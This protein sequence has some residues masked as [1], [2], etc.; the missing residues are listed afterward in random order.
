[1]D[2][3]KEGELEHVVSRAR[4]LG[5]WLEDR[6]GALQLGRGPCVLWLRFCS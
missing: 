5:V 1:M 4:S 2:P 3:G 6:W